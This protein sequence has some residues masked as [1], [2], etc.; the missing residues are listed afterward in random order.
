MY[1]T[2]MS[3]SF[4]LVCVDDFEQDALLVA[5]VARV[6]VGP[7]LAAVLP[8]VAASEEADDQGWNEAR[9]R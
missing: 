4:L 3:D 1:S 5:D 2:Y 6:Q 7:L 8:D 9:F